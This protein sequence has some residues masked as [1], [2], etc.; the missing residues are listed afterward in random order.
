MARYQRRRGSAPTPVD[1][2]GKPIQPKEPT[3]AE[4]DVAR[5]EKELR[6]ANAKQRAEEERE[7]SAARRTAEERERHTGEQLAEERSFHGRIMTAF[8]VG[9]ALLAVWVGSRLIKRS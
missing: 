3:P 1:Q 2:N 4:R 9:L 5:R 7:A 8:Y 6:D